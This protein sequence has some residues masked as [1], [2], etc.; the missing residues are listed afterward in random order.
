MDSYGII[1]HPAGHSLSPTIHNWAFASKGLPKIYQAWDISPE[2]LPDFMSCVRT[3]GIQGLS[4]TIPHKK[5][6]MP[7][8]D[9]LDPIARDIGAVNTVIQRKGILHGTNTDITGFLAPL[10][11]QG[12]KPKTALVLGAGGAARAAL[13]GLKTLGTEIFLTCRNTKSGELLA[14]ELHAGFVSWDDRTR[15]A[16]ELLIN[17][18]PLGMH[19]SNAHVS[20]WAGPLT[21]C[22]TCY[23]LVYTPQMTPFLNLA[24]AQGKSVISGLAMF[25]HQAHAQFRL[26][27]GQNFDIHG[28]AILAASRLA[29]R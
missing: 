25:I 17:A 21:G 3:L 23:D 10:I 13:Y 8:L 20:P 1:G 12:L 4:V 28:A 15:V 27:T 2:K 5:T 29:V 7:L 19:G 9:S 6:I 24:S 22:K 16:A 14:K 18:T 11:Y 26:W